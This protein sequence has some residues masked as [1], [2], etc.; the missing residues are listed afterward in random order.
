MAL[1][2]DWIANY[3]NHIH[4]YNHTPIHTHGIGADVCGSCGVIEE[5]SPLRGGFVSP[6]IRYLESR[7][8]VLTGQLT[9]VGP[10]ERDFASQSEII[11]RGIWAN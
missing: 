2:E 11:V 3:P 1:I 7:R 9:G 8:D 6:L 4:P 10:S 5:S